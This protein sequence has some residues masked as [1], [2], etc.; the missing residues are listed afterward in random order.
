[1]PWPNGIATQ[2]QVKNLVPS[3]QKKEYL[4]MLTAPKTTL[5]MSFPKRSHQTERECRSRS[6]TPREWYHM[7]GP[8]SKVEQ[9]PREN[10]QRKG[11]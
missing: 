1:M 6:Q 7:D 9:N 2:A 4:P 11:W 3:L 5:T 10:S 8:E